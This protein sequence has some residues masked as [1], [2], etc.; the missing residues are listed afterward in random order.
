MKS[1]KTAQADSFLIFGKR[2]ARIARS[3]PYTGKILQRWRNRERMHLLKLMPKDSVCA[4]IGVW[5]G[6][7]S[8]QI[9]DVVSPC[10]LFL[11]DPWLFQSNDSHQWHGGD[12]GHA[13]GQTA[14]DT[15]YSEVVDRFADVHSVSI[16]R[17]FSSDAV[18]M[19]DDEYF[20]WV[21]IDGNHSFEYV[22][23]DLEAYL[24]KVKPSGYLT[25]DDYLWS[26]E[27][28]FPVKRALEQILAAGG[29]RLIS[30]H[31][32]QWILQKP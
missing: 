28:G 18:S 23:G 31:R 17:S 10:R 14:M 20:D 6:S 26:P 5:K 27:E 4:E 7:F 9:L 2:L 1:G 3:L 29:A 19:F 16:V 13:T 30:V 11:I 24:P 22:L 12:K 25:G 21:Y 8:Q 32:G 15:I